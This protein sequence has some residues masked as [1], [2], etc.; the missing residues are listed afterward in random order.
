MNT[1]RKMVE[2]GDSDLVLML[3]LLVRHGL[4]GGYRQ[5]VTC[6][7]LLERYGG[8]LGRPERAA[9]V[10]EI[11]READRRTAVALGDASRKVAPIDEFDDELWLVIASMVE[12]QTRTGEEDE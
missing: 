12:H 4:A 5:G 3:R 9:L 1:N 7:E 11:R 6:A 2:V 10:E 8:R